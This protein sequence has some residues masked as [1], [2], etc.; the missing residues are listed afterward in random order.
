MT[1]ME[2]LYG[3]KKEDVLA[4]IDFLKDKKGES[5]SC[6]FEKYA[7]YSGKAKGT[8]RNLY[9]TISKLSLS[10]KAFCEKYLDGKPIT[11]E[12]RVEF[13]PCQER[14][15]LTQIIKKKMDGFSVRKAVKALALGEEKLALRYQNKFRSLLKTSPSLVKEIVSNIKGASD[16]DLALSKRS[17]KPKF[18]EMQVVRL[19]KEINSLFERTFIEL[20]KENALLREELSVIKDKNAKLRKLLYGEEKTNAVAEYFLSSGQ[21]ELIH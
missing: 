3:F 7:R 20:K 9:Y 6:L 12:E 14:A 21:K 18:N 11:V 19:K 2:N 1:C 8:I 16:I 4:L 17:A 13:L 10:D 5:L 15:L